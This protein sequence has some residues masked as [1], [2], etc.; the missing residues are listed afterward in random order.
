MSLTRV[1]A[2]QCD[3]KLG[4]VPRNA[5]MILKRLEDAA[6]RGAKLV[7]FPECALS[8]Y[9]FAS[10]KSAA[11]HAETVPGEFTARLVEAC[12]RLGVWA[13]V[14]MLE[15]SGARLFNAAVLAGPRGVEGVYRKVHLPHLGVDRFAAP[16]DRPFRVHAL[17]FGRIGI[18]IC[19]DNS[20]PETARALRLA[21]ADL[22]VLPTNWPEG[23]R[24]A[25]KHVC[26]TRVHENHVHLIAC[27]RVGTESGFRFIG[28]SQILD[29][30]GRVLAKASHARPAI[31][32][33]DLDFSTARRTRVVI[34]KGEYELDRVGHRRPEFY[35]SLVRRT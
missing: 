6:R 3:P 20:F 7:V 24:V 18:H 12:G 29:C 5:A 15:R 17:P 2:V 13:V 19:Y 23:A 16:G 11:R 33:G 1:A 25:S 27:N 35:G 8:G 31:L 32:T 28:R 9:G 10:R 21:G 30:V 14:G 4:D 26:I 34:K 22:L